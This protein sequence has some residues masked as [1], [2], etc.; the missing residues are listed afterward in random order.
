MR[1]FF[2]FL[3]FPSVYID[4]VGFR[5]PPKSLNPRFIQKPP[6]ISIKRVLDG[7]SFIGMNPKCFIDL[8]W[9]NE[10]KMFPIGRIP[11]EKISKKR[12]H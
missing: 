3:A 7:Q 4:L 2:E 1:W 8:N 12:F 5:L 6:E 11:K 9:K 10:P